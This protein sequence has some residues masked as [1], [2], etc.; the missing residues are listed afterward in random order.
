MKLFYSA[1]S[2][3][4][5]PHIALAESGLAFEL[6]AVNLRVSPHTTASG[7]EYASVNPKGYVPALLLDSGDVLSE[8]VAIVQY[9]ADQVP[10]KH[11]APANGTF[12]RY[13][14][15]E[16]L[17]FIATEIHKGFGPLWN[18]ATPE[19]LRAAALKR[20]ESRFDVLQSTLSASNYLLGGFSVADGYLFTCLNWTSFH[21]VSLDRWPALQAFMTRVG[22]RP[23]VQAAMKAEGLFGD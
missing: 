22:A 4:L 1:G 9:I 8:G 16:W 6:E 10:D 19:A 14:L 13:R 23:A 7:V 5:S 20:L 15:Q 11:L 21:N 18:P 12:E 17:N 3:S 2:C